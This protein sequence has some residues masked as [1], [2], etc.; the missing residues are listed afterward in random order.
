ME[1]IGNH[2]LL[3]LS[4]QTF[5][6]TERLSSICKRVGDPFF[7]CHASYLVNPLYVQSIERFSLTLT[8]GEKLPVP[9]KKYTSV[10]A[11]LLKSTAKKMKFS[12]KE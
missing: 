5:E 7:R 9:E 3:H 1:S 12:I 6:S 10:K 11:K 2:T 8:N 4:S